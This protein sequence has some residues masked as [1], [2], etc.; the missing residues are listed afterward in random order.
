MKLIQSIAP[1]VMLVVIVQQYRFDGIEGFTSRTKSKQRTAS[2]SLSSIAPPST[3]KEFVDLISRTTFGGIV[4]TTVGGIPDS[5]SAM[6]TDV[7]STAAG[8][9]AANKI[10]GKPVFAGE[11]IMS[12]KEHG[13][14]SKPVQ[15]DLLYGVNNNLADKIS[16]FNRQFAEPAG[17]FRSTSFEELVM[18]AKEPITFADSV[19]GKP[20]FVAP[21]GRSAEQF[22]AESKVHGW[23]SFRD[24]EV[25]WENVRVLKRS[26]E[27]VSADG[28]HLG[29]NLPDRA[30]NRYCINL[31]SIAGNPIV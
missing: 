6:T 18:N 24:E 14:S 7:V 4:A 2:T 5:A 26:G 17:Y 20:L 31:V 16:N 22:V 28:T 15:S 21:I 11:E 9:A 27:T 10:G 13:T 8:S 30:G 23:P 29:H 19:T 12:Q 3:R 1:Y 25:V